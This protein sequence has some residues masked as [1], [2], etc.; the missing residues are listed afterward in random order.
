MLW[1]WTL[2]SVR[3]DVDRDVMEMMADGGKRVKFVEWWDLLGLDNDMPAKKVRILGVIK[4]DGA[5]LTLRANR[6]AAVS[7]YSILG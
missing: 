7:L 1:D 3:R 2:D 4:R 5:H 6:V